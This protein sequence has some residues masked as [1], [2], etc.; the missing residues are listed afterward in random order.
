ML[1]KE[2]AVELCEALDVRATL[3]DDE[4]CD[5]LATN[6][7]TYLAALRELAAIAGHGS[8]GEEQQ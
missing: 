7:G 5:M 3:G 1:T 8:C 2:M 6:N 4:E